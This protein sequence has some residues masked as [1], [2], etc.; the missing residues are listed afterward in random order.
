LAVLG[1]L[2][3]SLRSKNE[4]DNIPEDIGLLNSAKGQHLDHL[5]CQLI[6]VTDSSPLLPA[7]STIIRETSIQFIGLSSAQQ[8]NLRSF[9]ADNTLGPA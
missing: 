3:K 2:F 6:K 8:H 9:L 5:S 4:S 7:S 1:L